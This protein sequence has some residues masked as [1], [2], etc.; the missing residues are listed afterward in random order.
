MKIGLDIH[1][2]LDKNSF[3]KTMAMLML[4]EGHE[5]HII[6]G[7]SIQLALEDLI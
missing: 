3:F 2:V 7:T 6:T 1:G 4:R 5:I